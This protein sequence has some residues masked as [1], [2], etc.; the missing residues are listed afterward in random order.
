MQKLENTKQIE[1]LQ[2]AL[3][4]VCRHYTAQCNAN[5]T[6]AQKE[7]TLMRILEI[8]G[9]VAPISV[10]GGKKGKRKTNSIMR[11]GQLVQQQD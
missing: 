9:Q 3:L 6:N 5:A 1:G 10:R 2:T 11:N 4:P 8:P 7:A